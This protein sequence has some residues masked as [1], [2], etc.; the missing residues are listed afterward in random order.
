MTESLL[1]KFF[2]VPS[3]LLFSSVGLD[4]SDQSIKFAELIPS[5]TGLEIG[6]YGF[7][8][9]PPGVM[10]AGKI[11]DSK[12][13]TEI[14]TTL[15]K[16]NGFKNVRV[17]LPEEQVYVFELSIPKVPYNEI[18]QTI[19][20]S[21]EEHIPIKAEEAHFDFL[22]LEEKESNYFLQVSAI[23]SELVE[24][25]LSVF[26]E[27]GL[28]PLSFE[29]E[30]QAIAR[31]IVRKGDPDT[32]MIVDFGETR[33]GISIVREGTILFA[34]TIDIGG[35][36][37]TETLAKAFSI[38]TSAAE[39]MKKNVGLSRKSEDKETFSVL[40]N[41][42]SVLRDEISKN[43]IYWHSHKDELGQDRPPVSEILLCGGDANLSGL[44]EYLTASLRTKV[45]LGNPWININSLSQYV[46]PMHAR[47]ALGYVT[48][49]GLALG[50]FDHD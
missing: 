33:T 45:T 47:E 29:L 17:S 22:I 5:S 16:K 46:P 8:A 6:R 13:F 50:D 44:S 23:S 27:A 39:E 26:E 32:L 35:A 24:D 21:I 40:L 1:S 25:Y 14:L 15:K 37:L 30:A 11:Q 4:I 31:A 7:V 28:S 48:A 19:E 10:Y 18:R 20:L 43:F 49:F 2:P 41:A 38:S 3:L 34:T 12:R 36:S 9:I 42:V